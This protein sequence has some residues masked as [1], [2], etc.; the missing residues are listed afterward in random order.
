MR[1]AIFN[2]IRLSENWSSAQTLSCWAS[3]RHY[4]ATLIFS[5]ASCLIFSACTQPSPNTPFPPYIESNGPV[6]A[7]AEATDTARA[8]GRGINLGNVFESP[9]GNG[10]WGLPMWPEY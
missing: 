7:S 8:L 9:Q 6:T 10:D 2:A 1:P 3:T 5:I 4:F